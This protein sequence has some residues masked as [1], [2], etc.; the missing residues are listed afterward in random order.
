MNGSTIKL[1]GDHFYFNISLGK[2]WALKLSFIHV[3]GVSMALALLKMELFV[4][5]CDSFSRYL[6]SQKTP[7]L[8]LRRS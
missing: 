7:S 1:L 3:I 4:T 5:L 8:L 2:F 6:L